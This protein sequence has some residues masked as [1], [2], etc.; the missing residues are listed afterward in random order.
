MNRGEHPVVIHGAV[1]DDNRRAAEAHD[2]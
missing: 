1:L 2:A